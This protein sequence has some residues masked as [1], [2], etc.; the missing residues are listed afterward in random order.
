MRNIKY[1]RVYN[2]RPSLPRYA[3]EPDC[4]KC[5]KVKVKKVYTETLPK[6]VK[7]YNPETVSVLD[8]GEVTQYKLKNLK[9]VAH[10]ITFS[11]ENNIPATIYWD[12][13]EIK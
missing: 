2:I 6:L 12:Y 7:Y 10:R 4:R 5:L 9:L 13:Y 1:S 8:N 3:G 11:D